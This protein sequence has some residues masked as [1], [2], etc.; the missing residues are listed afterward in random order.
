MPFAKLYYYNEIVMMTGGLVVT[1]DETKSN[2]LKTKL[3]RNIN[4]EIIVNNFLRLSS[5]QFIVN[6][7]QDCSILIKISTVKTTSKP[8]GNI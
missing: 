4:G 5:F 7:H 8:I 6:H 2:S 1:A 3:N